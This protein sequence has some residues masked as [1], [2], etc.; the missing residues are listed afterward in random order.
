MY[1]ILVKKK[2]MTTICKNCD[3]QFEGHFCN[4]CGQ[5][6]NT[7]DINLKYVLHELQHGIFHVDKGI[8]YTLKELFTRPGN[9]ILEFINGKRERLFK[10][11][12]SLVIILT[13]VYMLLNHYFNIEVVDTSRI[14]ITGSTNLIDVIQK[15]KTWANNHFVW[16]S[17]ISIPIYSVGTAIAFRAHKYN[18]IEHLVLNTFLVGQKLAVHIIAFPIVYLIK[19]TSYYNVFDTFVNAIDFVLL[20]WTYY[21]FFQK[22]NKLRAIWLAIVSYI[23]YSLTFVVLAIALIISV[24]LFHH[25]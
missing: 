18:F 22:K 11:L 3:Q 4:Q 19:D 17:L 15:I 2:G 25:N 12:T 6:A 10:P 21:R 5:P 1:L 7:H 24:Y 14:K 23:I 16:M 13:T 20:V 8:F 9:T